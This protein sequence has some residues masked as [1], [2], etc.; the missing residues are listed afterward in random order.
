MGNA[1]RLGR[2]ALVAFALWPCLGL[3]KPPASQF[4]GLVSIADGGSYTIIRSDTLRTGSKGATLVAG[5]IV[6][7]GPG[8]FLVLEL[9]GGSLLGIGPSTRLYFLQRA[10]IPTLVVLEGWIKADVRGSAKSGALRIIGTRLGI[11]GQRAVVL[12][13]ATERADEIF[14]EQGSATLLLRDDAATHIDRETQTRQFLVRAGRQEVVL[15][16]RPS[17][18]FV[19][20]MPIA[21]RDQLPDNAS[22]KLKERTEPKQVR[23]V[24]YADVQP[25]LTM[26]PDWR[27]GFIGRFRG[28]LKDPAFFAAM[29]AHLALHR[30]W[31][32]I[33]HPPPPDDTLQPAASGTVVPAAGKTGP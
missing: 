13:H 27:T 6:E 9:H 7:T 32:P 26:P 18:E 31:D 20:A 25:W 12:L 16:P 17:A 28:R 30:E 14:D 24:T 15:Q 3:A 21:F 1:R 29:E 33:L 8:A 11:Q 4:G 23:A 2:I 22:A 5:D 10:D 19:A